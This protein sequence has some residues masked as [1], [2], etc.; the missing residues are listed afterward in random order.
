MAGMPGFHASDCQ[1]NAVL[2]DAGFLDCQT[3][4]AY[5]E[6]LTKELITKGSD[7]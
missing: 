7:R 4:D 1:L 3:R 6:E 2:M 5:R